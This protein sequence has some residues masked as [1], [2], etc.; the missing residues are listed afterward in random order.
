MK[1][2]SSVDVAKQ[3]GVSRATVSYVLNNSKDIKIKPE[4]REKVLEAAA[5]LGYQ[6]NSIARAMKTKKSTC[7]GV[8]SKRKISQHRLVKVLSGIKDVLDQHGYSILL[9]SNH[10]MENGKPEY[11]NQ[12]FQGKIDGVILISEMEG[13]TE[14]DI[15]QITKEIIEHNIPSVFVDYHI[16]D[17]NLFCVDIDYYSGGV[18]GV[19][20]A[21]EKGY[22]KIIYLDPNTKSIQEFERIHGVTDTLAK[23]SNNK[24]N[25]EFINI[26]T[27]EEECINKIKE[28]LKNIEKDTIIIASWTIAGFLVLNIANS[29]KIL[30]PD[31]LG[32]IA[33]GESSFV[34]YSY[35]SLTTTDLP[36]HDVGKKSGE[37]IL[38]QI[39]NTT[40]KPQ[41]IKLHCRLLK[42]DSV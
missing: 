18:L 30:I 35:P 21:I 26:G 42:H 32:V 16:N 7:I 24:I 38:E 33:L 13:V 28:I 41:N 20:Y 12:Y 9:S 40:A 37:L 3:A 22:K 23:I 25:I 11:I 2:I 5:R 4:T 14:N 34:E 31:E 15:E 29:M 17:P 10:I 8:V 36:L 6:P 19:N 27:N 1:R 39:S